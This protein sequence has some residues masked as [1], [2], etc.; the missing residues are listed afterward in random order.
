MYIV[1]NCV[2]DECTNNAML[3][4]H[5]GYQRKLMISLCFGRYFANSCPI[6]VTLDIFLL[7]DAHVSNIIIVPAT[8]R[9]VP[10]VKMTFAG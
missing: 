8:E 6:H 5:E 1:T 4:C 3:H 2:C 10:C 9:T 7:K